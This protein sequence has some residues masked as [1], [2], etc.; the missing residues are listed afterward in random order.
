MGSF[1]RVASALSLPILLAIAGPA[2]AFNILL[3]FDVDDD[4]A[5]IRTSLPTGQTTATARFVLDVGDLPLPVDP[6]WVQIEEGC[7]EAPVWIAHYGTM[8]DIG[9]IAFDPLYVAFAQPAFP[10]CTYCCPWIIELRLAAGAPV[11]AGGRYFIGQAVWSA[12][13]LVQSACRPPTIF[14]LSGSGIAGSGEMVFT[15][16]VVG[17]DVGAWGAVKARWR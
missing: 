7:C 17:D 2:A 11:V 15:C 9:S 13:C 12:D 4:P 3:D 10:V 8:V 1:A 5:T 14:A 6:V 16:P